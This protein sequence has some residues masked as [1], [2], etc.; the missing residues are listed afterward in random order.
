MCVQ[1]HSGRLIQMYWGRRGG[2]DVN[3]AKD[4]SKWL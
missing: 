3:H 2:A 4:S 1:L